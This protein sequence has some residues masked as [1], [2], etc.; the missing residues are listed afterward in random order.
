ME[1][2]IQTTPNPNSKKFILSAMINHGEKVT[3]A[4]P[5]EAQ[6]IQLALAIF[7]CAGVKKIAMFGNTIT[8]TKAHSADWDSVEDEVMEAIS[9]KIEEHNPSFEV[10][11]NEPKVTY[12]SP[13]MERLAAIV[14]K[15]IR[16][17]MRADGGDITLL[18]YD[19]VSKTLFVSFEGSCGSCPSAID[20][21]LAGIKNILEMKFDED[22]RVIMA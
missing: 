16:P 14:E 11:S 3:F 6:G 19:T 20:G 9:L 8:V 12:D 10:Q 2:K 18:K 7:T 5:D 4:S 22:I 21:T 17:I 1:I 13:E 15:D